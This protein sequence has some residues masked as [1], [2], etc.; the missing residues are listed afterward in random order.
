MI[1][2]AKI[3]STVLGSRARTLIAK[4]IGLG[5]EGADDDAEQLD[6]IE[7]LQPLGVFAR[8]AVTSKLEALLFELGEEVVAAFFTDKGKPRFTDAEEGETRIYSA[9]DASCRVRLRADG[10]IDIEATSNK[11]IR[12]TA[13]GGANIVLNGGTLDVA[14]KTDAVSPSADMTTWMGQVA[15]AV[16]GLVPGAVAPPAPVSFATITGGAATV[17]A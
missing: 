1:R 3:A 2:F 6:D 15:A 5:D 14:R 7:V 4:A 17:K 16:N 12:I 10:S 9:A 13:T 11:N 8:P